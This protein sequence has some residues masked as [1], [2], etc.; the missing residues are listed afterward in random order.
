MPKSSLQLIL[1]S[2]VL[3]I[4]LP[5]EAFSGCGIP[6]FY[7]SFKGYVCDE[8]LGANDLIFWGDELQRFY[9]SGTT[10]PNGW[11]TCDE[12]D[13]VEYQIN[14]LFYGEPSLGQSSFQYL[15][16]GETQEINNS[17]TSV[18]VRWPSVLN[19]EQHPNGLFHATRN[20]NSNIYRIKIY[21]GASIEYNTETETFVG[22]ITTDG[23]G[24]EQSIEG[25]QA[26]IS[27]CNSTLG[28]SE[29]DHFDLQVYPNPTSDVLF[30]NPNLAESQMNIYNLKGQL[31]LQTSSSA[32]IDVSALEPGLY[33]IEALVGRKAS[34]S[35]S[36]LVF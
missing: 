18:W 16:S 11:S 21:D 20:E 15:D 30:I 24:N 36:F 6:I 32:Q 23:T 33:L 14:H 28:L 12:R 4:V 27:E 19:L 35:N 8:G 9:D 25:I 3:F 10:D 13:Y 22:E 31:M 2:L 5:K 17:T 1:V 7:N 26:I 34:Y 29:L